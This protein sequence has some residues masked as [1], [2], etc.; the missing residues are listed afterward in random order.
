[1]VLYFS[2]M[3]SWLAVAGNPESEKLAVL[4]DGQ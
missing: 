1:M 3:K 4:A 2:T